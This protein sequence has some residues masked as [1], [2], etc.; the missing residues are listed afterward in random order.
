MFDDGRLPHQECDAQGRRY[1][2]VRGG[3]QAIFSILPGILPTEISLG[4][5]VRVNMH[6]IKTYM[7]AR[8]VVLL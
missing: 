4:L 1:L 8:L 6:Y 3:G 2:N 7:R 5:H